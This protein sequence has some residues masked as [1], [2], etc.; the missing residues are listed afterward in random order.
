MSKSK[1][2][3]QILKSIYR[4]TQTQGNNTAF[5]GDIKIE[6]EHID[7]NTFWDL[8]EELINN[9]YL[10]HRR[11]GFVAL[12]E[13]GY[14]AIAKL[15]DS[16]SNSYY[17]NINI[18]TAINSPIQHGINSEMIQNTNYS[19]PDNEKLQLLVEAFEN[20]LPEL[21]LSD[22]DVKKVKAQVSTIKSQLSDE[23]DPVIISQAGR[24]LRNITEGAIGSLLASASQPGIWAMVQNLLSYFK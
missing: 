16:M 13:E 24:T 2:S 19:P 10:Q 22:K 7:N 9:G 5:L 8:C 18:G 21:S 11:S 12:S 23:P 6:F 3:D 17:N 15:A 14:D 4:K 1:L 20:H